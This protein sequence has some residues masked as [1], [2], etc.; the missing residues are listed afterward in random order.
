M[1]RFSEMRKKGYFRELAPVVLCLVF[2][3]YQF[4]ASFG[5]RVY[6]TD[7]LGS[8]F[9]PRVT[10]VIG[11]VCI[12][13][14][15]LLNH[16]VKKFVPSSEEAESSDAA[17]SVVETGPHT[18]TGIIKKQ[19]GLV[20]LVLI[21]LYIVCM[22]PLGFILATFLYLCAQLFLF[23]SPRKRRT[24]FIL[25]LSAVFSASVYFLFKYAFSVMLPA[26]I[27]G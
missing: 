17:S 16:G 15:L 14:I 23:V 26:G 22:R 4:A 27:L 24:A 13:L 25:L 6:K 3:G 8:N 12:L 5:L 19:S 7:V 11:V 10:S 20:T 21:A 2:F 9:M 18:I 1:K